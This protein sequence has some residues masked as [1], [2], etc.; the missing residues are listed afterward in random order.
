MVVIIREALCVRALVRLAYLQIRHVKDSWR[1]SDQP[2]LMVA[3]H[4]FD[5]N[6]SLLVPKQKYI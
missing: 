1:K 6:M 5:T 3:F 4:P 2:F